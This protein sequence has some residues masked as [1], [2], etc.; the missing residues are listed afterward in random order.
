LKVDVQIGDHASDDEEKTSYSRSQP[1]T[2]FP[3]QKRRAMP[4]SMGMTVTPNVFAP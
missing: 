4:R 1:I 2:L 3:F